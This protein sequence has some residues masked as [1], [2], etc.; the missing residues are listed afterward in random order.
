VCRRVFLMEAIV[1]LALIVEDHASLRRTLE[2]ALKPFAKKILLAENITEGLRLLADE[3]PQLILT[4]IRLPDGTGIEV[5]RAAS[6]MKPFPVVIALSGEATAQ[7]SFRL[8]QYGVRGYLSKPIE[9]TVLNETI[10]HALT[11]APAILTGLRA[12]VGKVDLLEFEDSVRK[13]LIEEALAKSGGKKAQAAA[14]LSVSRQLL[15]HMMRE[16]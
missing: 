14:L 15:Q 12:S 3:K 11:D 10:R 2:R 1:P 7:E 8:A 9:F 13:T 5:A 6:L 4:D 16:K